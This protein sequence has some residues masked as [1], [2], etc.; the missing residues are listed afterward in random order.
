MIQ[1]IPTLQKYSLFSYFQY[2][3]KSS[4]STANLQRVVSDGTA[5]GFNRSGATR[6]V[7]LDISK[8]FH[9]VWYAGL[10]HKLKS[11]GISVQIFGL[12][13]SFLSGSRRFRVVLDG[14][15]SLECPVNAGFP[16][17]FY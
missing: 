9:R 10:P 13:L 14:K 2:G 1:L 4:R 16:H 5:R 17:F 3:F 12:I 11:Y 15:S 6:A 7:A 8:A